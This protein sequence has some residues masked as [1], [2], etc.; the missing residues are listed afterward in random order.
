MKSPSHRKHL[1]HKPISIFIEL[2]E[3]L[4]DAAQQ[5]SSQWMSRISDI[6]DRKETLYLKASHLGGNKFEVQVCSRG[7]M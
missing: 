1:I 4:H 7:G 2:L 3:R 6:V 5:S